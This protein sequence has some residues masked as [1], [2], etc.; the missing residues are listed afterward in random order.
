[1]R[2]LIEYNVQVVEDLSKNTQ[3]RTTYQLLKALIR[4]ATYQLRIKCQ[5]KASRK[6][7][8]KL[9][10]CNERKLSKLRRSKLKLMLTKTTFTGS[11]VK[12]K[13]NGD[14]IQRSTSIQQLRR[15]VEICNC[16]LKLLRGR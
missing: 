5:Y 13:K 9:K 16:S 7:T 10:N 1:M 6:V 15:S 4:S 14:Y 2:F 3:R 8:T 11:N 12:L